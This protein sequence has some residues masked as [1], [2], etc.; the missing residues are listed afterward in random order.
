MFFFVYFSLTRSARL[1]WK[2]AAWLRAAL[3]IRL[4]ERW[5]KSPPVT[6]AYL[7]ALLAAAAHGA[8]RSTRRGSIWAPRAVPGFS[9]PRPRR[10]ARGRRPAAGLRGRRPRAGGRRRPVTAERAGRLLQAARSE[11]RREGSGRSRR[12]RIGRKGNGRGLQRS[13]RAPIGTAEASAKDGQAT[14]KKAGG[15]EDQL[16]GLWAAEAE[17]AWRK[18]E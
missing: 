8:S 11:E 12:S 5:P 18:R 1:I 14:A 16:E 6:R 4:V 9:R 3:S 2:W 10:R 7:P 15:K 13:R 17:L